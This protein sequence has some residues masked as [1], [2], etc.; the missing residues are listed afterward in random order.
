ML[1][2]YLEISKES[3]FELTEGF[4]GLADEHVWR[5]PGDGLLSIGEIAGHVAYWQAVKFAG[6]MGPAGP[7]LTKC[8][9]SSP[10]IDH[11]F[12]YYQTTLAAAPSPEHLAMTASQVCAEVVRVYT[13]SID[14]F[15]A[16]NP[17]LDA[18]PPGWPPKY[19]YRAL[20]TY[21]P[22]HVAYHTGQIY[23]ARHLF[24]EQPPDN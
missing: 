12:R 24:G 23:S 14:H 8:R 1:D 20:L 22:I 4:R 5:R 18:C 19:S 10:L 21:A 17:A 13:E 16:A 3:Y 9:V 7:D 6:E 15:R 2:V 11:R